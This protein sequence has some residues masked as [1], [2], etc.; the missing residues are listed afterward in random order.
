MLGS[1]RLTADAS[2]V[3]EDNGV[4]IPLVREVVSRVYQTETGRENKAEPPALAD[5]V[6]VSNKKLNE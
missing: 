5:F 1:R 4:F 6:S 3:Y 2:C